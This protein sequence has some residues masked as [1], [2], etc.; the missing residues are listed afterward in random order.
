MR[1]SRSVDARIVIEKYVRQAGE[2]SQEAAFDCFDVVIA[3]TG[4]NDARVVVQQI[5]FEIGQVVALDV[6]KAKIGEASHVSEGQV[7][8]G[9]TLKVESVKIREESFDGSGEFV[10]LTVDDQP[11]D[12]SI[13]S[14]RHMRSHN[15]HDGKTV[16]DCLNSTSASVDRT[17]DIPVYVLERAVDDHPGR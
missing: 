9:S 13:G 2:T 14:L 17:H 12:V 3:K 4:P 1:S 11:A 5:A 6:Q 10:K 15:V 7:L 8:D 16:T